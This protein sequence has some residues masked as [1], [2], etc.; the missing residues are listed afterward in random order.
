MYS[1]GQE[2]INWDN[3]RKLEW[4]DFKAKPQNDNPFDA[5]THW[6]VKYNT[7][8]SHD[9]LVFEILCYV[10]PEKSWVK[11]EDKTAQLLNH[12][13]GHFDIGELF[14]RKLRK[15]LTE[16]HFTIDNMQ[17][18]IPQIYNMIMQECTDFQR[19]YDKETE[20]SKDIEEQVIWDQKIAG[21]MKALSAYAGSRIRLA[22]KK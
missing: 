2:F 8:L 1:Y 11:K 18:E 16:H 4:S 6:A 9:T 10:E 17:K 7:H 21:S 12:E 14:T 15:A 5:E 3:N 22:L 13:Q 19:Q 20:H